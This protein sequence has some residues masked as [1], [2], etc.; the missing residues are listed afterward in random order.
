MCHCDDD[1]NLVLLHTAFVWKVIISYRMI[2]AR[3]YSRE[4]ADAIIAK[5]EDENTISCIIE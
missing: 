3:R 2:G 1:V 4:L 5:I